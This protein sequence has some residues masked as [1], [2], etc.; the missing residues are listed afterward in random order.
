V[1]LLRDGE[2]AYPAM[3]AAIAGARRTVCME[4][5]TFAGDRVGRTFGEALRAA[6]A[7]GAAVRLVAD[8]IGSMATPGAFWD[9]LREAGV[10]VLLYRPAAPWRR[11]WGWMRRDHRKILVVDRRIAF[12]GG[13]N[14]GV[15]YAPRAEGG[16]GWRDTAIRLEGDVAG[17]L[18]RAFL[19]TWNA[20][21]ETPVPVPDLPR[22]A[23]AAEPLVRV[24]GSDQRRRRREIHRAYVRAI[25]GARERISIANAYFVP[26]RT[27]RRALRQAARRGVEVR[28]IV[29]RWTDVLVVHFASRA[30]FGGLLRAGVRIFE[31]PA[32][33]M[34]AKTAVIDGRWST[35]GSFNIDHRSLLHNLEI[36][37]A[38]LD[39]GFGAE[40]EAM[41]EQDLA[42]C[43]E[44][45]PTAWARRSWLHRLL[46]HVAY[47]FERWV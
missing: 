20:E 24:L 11:R 18:E 27:V 7:R 2:A 32:A 6:A 26:D 3:L 10:D 30:L 25:R 33:M 40:M 9:W 37:V 15:E 47:W 31:W 46:E 17:Q 45:R 8:A 34:H 39:R 28:V 44:I 35:V 22:V 13:I 16:G 1:A 4:S 19:A 5:Y 29:S 14:I 21:S 23:T 41:F 43:E 36:N 38:V 42:Q 12:V